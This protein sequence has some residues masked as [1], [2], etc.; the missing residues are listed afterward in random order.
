M[1]A[2]RSPVKGNWYLPCDYARL[3]RITPIGLDIS[4]HRITWRD[5]RKVTRHKTDLGDEVFILRLR[6][7]QSRLC[8]V[9]V[10]VHTRPF[11]AAL[12]RSEKTIAQQKKKKRL[13]YSLSISFHLL[14]SLHT[15]PC[16]SIYIP[17]IFLHLPTRLEQTVQ[18]T[19]A[20]QTSAQPREQ[21]STPILLPV[22]LVV[23][24]LRRW[25]PLLVVHALLRLAIALALWRAVLALW[26]TIL[27]LRWS[28]LALR[29]L[30]L[31]RWRAVVSLVCGDDGASVVVH[32]GWR[33]GVVGRRALVVLRVRVN[34]RPFNRF[35][36]LCG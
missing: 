5:T 7:Y 3:S 26:R 28:V 34:K 20:R 2:Y 27:A 16:P 30:A 21:S 32:G 29:I 14:S 31:R 18:A 9:V 33:R 12:S 4:S 36:S 25:R 6:N 17:S 22:V 8:I 23:A 24:S 11:P 10:C 13:K 15:L 1:P 35:A 19:T